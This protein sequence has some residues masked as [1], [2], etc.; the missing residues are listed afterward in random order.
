MR[1]LL[2]R[3]LTFFYKSGTHLYLNPEH[4]ELPSHTFGSLS[5]V[6]H[7]LF[8][9]FRHKWNE[10][11]TKM[12]PVLFVY[13]KFTRVRMHTLPTADDKVDNFFSAK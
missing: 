9:P 1:I 5:S 8:H 12:F 2:T 10:G 4:S 6:T 11:G 3:R 7:P 13:I